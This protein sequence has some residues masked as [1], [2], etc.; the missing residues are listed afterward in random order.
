MRY[1]GGKSK[2]ARQLASMVNAVRC[3]RPVL[4][5]FC[6]GLATA[7]AFGEPIWCNDR[8][9][10]LIE[11]YRQ[12]QR[13]D[14]TACADLGPDEY[15]M[16]RGLP[17]S[18]PRKAFV[19]FGC[20][21]G[22]RWFAGP[23]RGVDRG[24]QRNYAREARDALARKM[25]ALRGAAFTCADFFDLEPRADVVLYADPP[26]AGTTGYQWAWDAAAFE[27]RICEWMSVTDVF[28]SEYTFGAGSVVWEKAQQN[29]LAGSGRLRVERLYYGGP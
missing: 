1:H 14:M 12:V 16:S 4:D 24:R 17:D 10:G 18:S 29:T 15:A 19:G 20:S 11:L 23:A 3:G 25:R 8:H 28:V 22:G 13:G 27:R 21:Y 5:A 2:I 26:Y 6:G 7:C 9:P